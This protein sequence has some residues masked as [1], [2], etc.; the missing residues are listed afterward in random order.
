MTKVTVALKEQPSQLNSS[1]RGF[2]FSIA[3]KKH[4]GT[5]FDKLGPRAVVETQYNPTQKHRYFDDT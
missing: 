4:V 2:L 3:F 1:T 5:F